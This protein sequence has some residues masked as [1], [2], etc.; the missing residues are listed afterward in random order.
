MLEFMSEYKGG[1]DNC[2]DF[3]YFE[4]EP[5]SEIFSKMKT[6]ICEGVSS[7]KNKELHFG[8]GKIFSDLYI[9]Q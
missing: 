8:S 2:E 9:Y 1:A 4:R 3:D 5:P 7:I 6:D